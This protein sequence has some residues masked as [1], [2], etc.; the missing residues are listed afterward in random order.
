MCGIAGQISL[1]NKADL[2]RSELTRMLNIIKHRGPDGEGRFESDN[3]MFGMRRLSI[4]DLE[5]G[6]QPIYN[7]DKT[8]VCCCNGEIYN[9]VELQDE[10]RRQGHVLKTESD[11]EVIVHLYEEFS[12]DFVN[13]LNGMFAIVLWDIRRKVLLLYRDRL[14]KKPLYYSIQNGIFYFA[15][16]IKCINVCPGIIRKCNYK[17]LDYLLTYNYIPN[18]MT[19]FE[20]V[21]KLMPGEYIQVNE[22]NVNI[23]KYWELGVN[24]EGFKTNV[25]EERHIDEL[26]ELM[27]DATR[28]RLRSDVPVGAFLSGGVDSGLIVALA[29]KQIDKLQTF[30]IGFV[31]KRF[32]ESRYSQRVADIFHTVHTSQVVDDK[33]FELLPTTI[34]LNDDPHGDISFL[35][36]YVLANIT[37][38]HVKTVL[39]GDGGDE[40]FGGYDK[41]INYLKDGEADINMFF[42]KNSVFSEEQKSK[43]YTE[44]MRKNLDD[45]SCLSY[46]DDLLHEQ[47]INSNRCDKLNVLLYLETKLLLEG[48]NLVKPDRMGMGNSI[49]ARMPMLDY[50][51]VEYASRLCSKEKVKNYESK[52]LLKK[53][54]ARFLPEDIV[55]R[56]K[57]MFTVPIGEWLKGPLKSI[58]YDILLSKKAMDRN[59]FNTDYVKYMLD[60]HSSGAEN[61][62][63]QLRLLIIVELW[64]RIYIDEMYTE[65][66]D[67][68]K[69][70]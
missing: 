64:H 50:R 46:I 70:V 31:E 53:I 16:E 8:I 19:S 9:Y 27:T 15:S 1:S 14:G 60:A 68:K 55:Y 3:C 58:A 47:G 51:V 67:L 18:N 35:P 45:K 30:S 25:S 6:W 69:L 23:G 34:W 36:S 26:I 63:R 40:L 49:E 54:A 43:L 59:L 62:T 32:D 17:A 33:F 29:S 21:Y 56:D 7:E 42:E 10:L 2:K 4:I 65:I 38:K 57:Q 37:S 39:T 28:L 5:N 20:N 11:T 66:P 22:G 41:Y 44:Y 24:W 52:Y 61:Y 12:D 13:R 48:N